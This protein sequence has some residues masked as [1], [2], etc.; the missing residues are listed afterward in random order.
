MYGKL[1]QPKNLLGKLRSP[2]CIPTSPPTLIFLHLA[3]DRKKY[4]CVKRPI[5]SSITIF[6]TQELP[7]SFLSNP[8]LSSSHL[9]TTFWWP[10]VVSAEQSK[11]LLCFYNFLETYLSYD[12]NDSTRLRTRFQ[13]VISLQPHKENKSKKPL[14]PDPLMFVRPPFHNQIFNIGSQV[15]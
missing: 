3:V 8:K 2:V 11:T 10:R 6:S 4:E 9:T 13:P 12:Q 14:V 1:P 5:V 15:L 7:S